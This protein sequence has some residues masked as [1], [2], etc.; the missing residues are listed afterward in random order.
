VKRLTP[1]STTQGAAVNAAPLLPPTAGFLGSQQSGIF[2]IDYFIDKFNSIPDKDWCMSML[3]QGDQRCALGH[4]GLKT[5]EVAW[6][7]E[8]RA[9]VDMANINDWPDWC[10][11]IVLADIND[12]TVEYL[13]YGKTPKDRIVNYL[14]EIKSVSQVYSKAA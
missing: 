4:C 3:R 1:Q 8:V 2:N 9:L 13:K 10:A 11:P 12:G 14:K 6:S 5:I 7:D